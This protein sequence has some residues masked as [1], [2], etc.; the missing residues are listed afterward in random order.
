MKGVMF[1][2]GTSATALLGLALATGTGSV[3]GFIPSPPPV[4]GARSSALLQGSVHIQ[5]T[6]SLA[7]SSPR[8]KATTL[9]SLKPSEEV[10]AGGSA[11]LPR[12]IFPGVARKGL[13]RRISF[14][15]R[16]AERSDSDEEED[17][18]DDYED[19][20]IEEY[21]DR[22]DDGLD[23]Y[24]THENM[25]KNDTRYQVPGLVF[26]FWRHGDRFWSLR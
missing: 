3:D 25:L 15:R 14:M 4:G 7:D 11:G 6:S 13:G 22:D 8:A 18:E 24:D 19:E 2:M 17:D 5:K 23:R 10:R 21:K 16:A 12:W 9:M 26:A 1:Q 20:D